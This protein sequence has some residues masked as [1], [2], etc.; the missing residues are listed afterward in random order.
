MRLRDRIRRW[1]RLGPRTEATP[2]Q[3]TRGPVDHVVII[4]GSMSTLR[5]GCETNAGLTYKLLCDLAPNGQMSLRYEAGIQWQRWRSVRD[6][7]EGRGINRQI[8][9][10]YGAIASRYRPG[11][12]IFLFGYNTPHT[13]KPAPPHTS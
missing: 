10:V 2:A 4:D 1:F 7:V 8:R 3:R 9:R 13:N 11:D 5:E 6:V 12:R